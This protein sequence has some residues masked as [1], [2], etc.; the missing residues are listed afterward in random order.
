MARRREEAAWQ[1]WLLALLLGL[2]GAQSPAKPPGSP[3]YELGRDDGGAFLRGFEVHVRK[4]MQEG[5]YDAAVTAVLS[6]LKAFEPARDVP[7]V[8]AANEFARPFLDLMRS[9]DWTMSDAQFEDLVRLQAIASNLLRCSELKSA[10]AVLRELYS[11]VFANFHKLLVLT[12][13][14]SGL[15]LNR[16]LALRISP[17]ATTSWASGYT[18]AFE[19]GGA[20]E[21]TWQNLQEHVRFAAATSV[22]LD[23]RMYFAV[24]YLDEVLQR[25]IKE[26]INAQ[27]AVSLAG[28]RATGPRNPKR[29]GIASCFYRPLHSV[30]QAMSAFVRALVGHFSLTLVS[31][32]T[33]GSV[34]GIDLS[35]FERVVHVKHRGAMLDVGGIDANDFAALVYLDVGMNVESV[36]LSNTRLAPVQIALSGHPVSTFGSQIDYFFSGADVEPPE[37]QEHYSERL[38]LLPGLG[39]AFTPLAYVPRRPGAG[40]PP[41][42]PPSDPFIFNLPWTSQKINWPHLSKLV[43]VAAAARRP[44]LFRFF[45]AMELGHE[46]CA[47]RAALAA[48]FASSPFASFEL[49]PSLPREEFFGKLEEGHAFADSHPFVGCNSMLNALHLRIPFL[50]QSSPRLLGRWGAALLRQAGMPELVAES[51]EEYVAV[52]AR[53]A[54]DAAFHAAARAKFA[55]LDLGPSGELFGA[56]NAPTFRAALEFLLKN[57][58]LIAAQDQQARAAGQPRLPIQFSLAS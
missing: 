45:A 22:G 20:E 43:R 14:R 34:E 52:A 24:T 57:H 46:L 38:V 18:R 5:Q 58:E 13:A 48:A 19:T 37:A 50:T 8:Q 12:S 51:D 21:G 3:E 2:A 29:I 16:T 30:H 27:A 55:A 41:L 9:P 44:V 54:S 47:L 40:P 36:L 33:T 56:R 4:L 11:D 17:D 28:L 49:F 35:A 1:L 26:A 15:Q 10:D 42:P 6:V 25:P 7:Y 31:L 32:G 53:L 39:T 23:Y